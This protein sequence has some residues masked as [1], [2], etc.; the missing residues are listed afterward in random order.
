[1]LHDVTPLLTLGT[2]INV[3][4]IAPSFANERVKSLN[5]LRSLELYA[6]PVADFL[7]KWNVFRHRLFR[8]SCVYH[9]GNYVKDL[10]QLGRPIDQVVILD[11]SPASYMFHATNA[12][13]T[14]RY[15]GIKEITGVTVTH[16]NAEQ[17]LNFSLREIEMGEENNFHGKE[18]Q[19]TSWFDDK[20]DKALLELIPYFQRLA[21]GDPGNVV[22]FLRNNPPPAQSASVGSFTETNTAGTSSLLTMFIRR[23]SES[24]GAA[25]N[26]NPFSSSSGTSLLS[27][28]TRTKTNSK[29]HTHLPPSD[30]NPITSARPDDPCLNITSK[31]TNVTPV[32]SQST[33]NTKTNT[34]FK[35]QQIGFSLRQSAKL[36][37][38]GYLCMIYYK[39]GINI[40]MESLSV[41]LFGVSSKSIAEVADIN[42]YHRRGASYLQSSFF[43]SP[44]GKKL[45]LCCALI[46]TCNAQ[47]LSVWPQDKLPLWHG[48]FSMID[49]SLSSSGPIITAR[50]S[51]GL[52]EANDFVTRRCCSFA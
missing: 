23:P 9:R 19:I 51:I 46:S 34:T 12:I 26:A 2:Q 21:E 33:A 28:T 41:M 50:S 5:L 47:D 27:L 45:L 42:I 24:S 6:D 39:K 32:S 1:M 22:E 38:L 52:S 11:N 48:D 4:L 49:F 10:S 29:S 13:D 7:D 15:Y 20:S 3:F 31:T 35:Y 14:F 16:R 30:S 18:V 8:E 40:V 17:F 43:F 25:T 37:P 36:S 44:L